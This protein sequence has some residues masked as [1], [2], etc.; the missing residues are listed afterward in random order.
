MDDSGLHTPF[1]HRCSC[2]ADKCERAWQKTTL[3]GKL[4]A[5]KEASRTGRR[6]PAWSGEGGVR[7]V[8]EK[9]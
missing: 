2:A 7:G 8:R 4:K 9:Y 5:R 3:P 6:T 1:T